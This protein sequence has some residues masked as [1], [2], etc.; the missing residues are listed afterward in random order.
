MTLNVSHTAAVRVRAG[1]IETVY[2]TFGDASAPPMLLIMG[3][4]GQMIAWDD[5]FCAQLAARG[6]WVIRYDNRDIGLATKFSQAGL[7][8]VMGL[9]QKMSLGQDVQVPYELCDMADDAVGLLDALEIDKAHIVGVSMGGMIAQ[10]VAIHYPQRVR[11][12]TSIMSTTGDLGLPQASPEVA[13]LLVTPAPPDRA[14]YIEHSLQNG[15]VLAGPIYPVD[16]ELARKKA[17]QYFDRGLCPEGVMRQLAAV[18]A[19]GSR[20]EALRSV[21]A[22]TL[23]IHGSADPL[24][25]VEGGVDTA[26]AVPG[27]ELLIIEGMGHALPPVLC[28]QIIEAI[29]KHA[30]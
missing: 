8:D 18:V 4:G 21:N 17:G 12:L 29:A 14:G 1:S 13:A 16:E 23:V 25:P 6:Y 30:V 20:K 15:R 11:T 5:E 2:D 28:P 19:S 27:A 10:S 26:N 7:P 3:L 24:I 9:M 22:P